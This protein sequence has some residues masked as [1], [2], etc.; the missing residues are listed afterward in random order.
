VLSVRD[1]MAKLIAVIDEVGDEVERAEREITAA[2]HDLMAIPGL[3]TA[4]VNPT[5]QPAE[6]GKPSTGW[7]Y[8][9]CEFR[10]VRGDIPAG[11]VQTPHNH[12]AW[13]ILAVYRGAMHY[14]SYRRRDDRSEPYFADLEVAEDR[15]MSEGDVTVLPAP[16]HDIHAT[17][18]LAPTT[19]SLLVA[20]GEF[21]SMREQ[22]LPD[23]RSYYLVDAATAAR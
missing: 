3:D 2:M 11:F 9:D 7:L 17:A 13:N 15:V 8:Y 1:A 4:V 23:L 16:P 10:L 5:A 19:V 14:R 22:Y 18:G 20:R 21:A 12:G 6:P